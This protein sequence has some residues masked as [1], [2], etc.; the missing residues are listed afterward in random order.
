ME[1]GVGRGAPAS[2]IGLHVLR[3]AQRRIGEL[4]Q[5]NRIGV[6]DEHLATAIAQVVLSH[7][8]R[9]SPASP[10]IDKLVVFGCVEGEHHDFPARLAADALDLAGYDVR[11]LGADVPT[12][13]LM[14]MIRRECPDL[15]ALSA[16]MSF[17]LRSL[18]MTVAR[19]RS[20]F[21]EA[22]PILVGGAACDTLVDPGA[23]LGADGFARDTRDLIGIV[24][25]LVSRPSL[26]ARQQALGG[27]P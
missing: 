23:E 8:Y 26:R 13:S 21:G 15:V 6:A 24:G 19:L 25:R 16:T 2:E 1:E 10:L 7:L 4:W 27:H 20:D 11:F 12:E 22:L 5:D 14:S 18:R 3:A 9:L 17:N